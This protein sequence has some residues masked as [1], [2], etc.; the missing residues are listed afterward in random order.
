VK[1]SIN[2]GMSSAVPTRGI[3]IARIIPYA[4][5]RIV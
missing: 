3:G 1:R 5:I 2:C 4:T